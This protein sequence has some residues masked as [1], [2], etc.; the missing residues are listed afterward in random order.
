MALNGSDRPG[1][2]LPGE[3]DIM[4]TGENFIRLHAQRSEANKPKLI[5]DTEKLKVIN[6]QLSLLLSEHSN[7]SDNDDLSD[8]EYSKLS[9]DII[10]KID[11]LIN[12]KY[13]K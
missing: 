10:T 4:A 2:H 12:A 9:R 1:D 11:I 8:E 5:N 3:R 7:L 13:N 6:A